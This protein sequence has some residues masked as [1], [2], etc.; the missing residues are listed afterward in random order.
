MRPVAEW[1]ET[2]LE[3]HKWYKGDVDF[4]ECKRAGKLIR[5]KP[6]GEM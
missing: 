3:Y 6:I 1:P 2:N 5:G 4:K